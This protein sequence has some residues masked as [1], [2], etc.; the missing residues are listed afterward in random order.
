M[1][2]GFKNGNLGVIHTVG[3]TIG[4]H[5][6]AGATA[7]DCDTAADYVACIRPRI[8]SQLSSIEH[9]LSGCTKKVSSNFL[10]SEDAVLTLACR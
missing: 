2:C 9:F 5:L 1:S 7:L 6:E 10:E 3:W 4:A 8:C